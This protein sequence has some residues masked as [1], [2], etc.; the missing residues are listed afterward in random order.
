MWTKDPHPESGFHKRD[1]TTLSPDEDRN[2]ERASSD[3]QDQPRRSCPVLSAHLQS[4]QSSSSVCLAVEAE[5]PLRALCLSPSALLAT[6]SRS[7]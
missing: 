3:F 6:T 7:E 2:K 5:T 4:G 1:K